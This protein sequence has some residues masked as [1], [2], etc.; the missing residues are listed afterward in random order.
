MCVPDTG[1]TQTIISE[2]MA[3][4]ANLN[5]NNANIRLLNASG[6]NMNV[7]GET[8][9][10]I[11]NDKYSID[12]IAIVAR[13]V[14]HNV[15]VSWHDLQRLGVIPAS[16][17]ACATASRMTCL[18][19]VMMGEFP[20]VFKDEL[21]SEPMKVGEMRIHLTE[22]YVPYKVS[23]P[24]QVP[25]RFQ[26]EAGR[27]V[28]DLLESG[29]ITE[30]RE[31]TDWCAPAFFVP[32]ADGKRVRLVTDY[33]RLNKFVRR[34]VHPFPSVKEIV[35]SIPTGMK[36]FAKMDAVHGYFQ[37]GLD[38]EASKLTTFILPSGR[39]RYLRAPMGLSSSSD[40][41]C[42]HSDRA[43]EGLHF[44][45]KIVDDILVWAPSLEELGNRVRQIANRC[46]ALN[47]ILSR[48]KF[49]IGEE[50][51]FAGLIINANGIKPDPTQVEALRKFPR[52]KDITGVRSFLGLANQLSGFVPDFAHMTKTLRGLTGKN[53]SFLWLQDH[54]KE[55]EEVKRLLT[56]DMVVTHF[57]PNLD[58]V[59][60]TDASR[61][62]GLGFVM[63]HIVDGRLRVVM[64]GSKS[65]TPAQ[66]RYSTVELECLGVHYAIIKCSFYLKG[67]DMFTVMTDHRPLEG[68]F[69]KDLFDLGNPRLQRIREKLGEYSFKV[70]WVPGKTHYIADAL[71]RSPVFDASDLSD[72]TIDTAR[73][74]LSETSPGGLSEILDNIDGD[75]R[76]LRED[77]MKGEIKSDRSIQFKSMFHRLSVDNELVYADGN[78]LVLP[79]K[80]VSKVL[81]G[82][83]ASHSGETKTYEMA[84]SMYYWPGMYNDVTQ[85]IQNCGICAKY[86]ASQPHGIRSTEPP[87]SYY[88]PPMQHIGLDMCEYGGKHYLV[89]VDH[90]S[91]FPLFQHMKS[92]SAKSICDQL[93]NWFNILGWP[94][95]I[96]S[97]GGPQFRGDFL[98]FCKDNGI[99]SEISAP[100]NPRSNGLAESGVKTV[101]C[102]IK[103]SIDTGVDPQRMLYSWRNVPRAH[104]YSPAQQMFG[105]QQRLDLPQPPV[106]FSQID[107]EKASQAR[108]NQ[109]NSSELHYNRD[110]QTLPPLCVNQH[111]L[112]QDPKSGAWLGEGLIQ[113]V[114][115]DGLSYVV[116]VS[117]RQCIR[118]RHMLKIWTAVKGAVKG[119]VKADHQ[120]TETPL[121]RSERLRQSSQ[122]EVLPETKWEEDHQRSSNRRPTTS[123][124][125]SSSSN[126]RLDSATSTVPCSQS[127]GT[128]LTGPQ[129][130]RRSPKPTT[131]SPS[132]QSTRQPLPRAS[133][134]APS[135]SSSPSS[136]P[137]TAGAAAGTSAS[138]GG[139]TT[140]SSSSSL[141]P[142]IPR[143]R[144]PRPSLPMQGRSLPPRLQSRVQPLLQQAP[145]FRHSFSNN[146]PCPWVGPVDHP[147]TGM[148]SP[149]LQGCTSSLP[150]RCQDS[151]TTPALP[152][153]PAG[154]A[155]SAPSMTRF[156]SMDAQQGAGVRLLPRQP[157]DPDPELSRPALD[158]QESPSKKSQNFERLKV[159]P[160]HSVNSF[161]TR[162]SAV[163]GSIFNTHVYF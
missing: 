145:R 38:E 78:R 135:F 81:K 162:T 1:S 163:P 91:G 110:K 48:K 88:G 18:K 46:K 83:H 70:K 123:W 140:T 79:K 68:V 94:S 133:G 113:A 35:Q 108:D 17:P 131:G 95:T 100:Y 20:S 9:V 107:F 12:T 90:W 22:K 130:T 80:A 157:K 16:F 64:C 8:K 105:R 150:R 36:F 19:E 92:L 143:P 121:R 127:T 120:L 138:R 58:A 151:G 11:N 34:P 82:L 147:G 125:S 15:L 146:G 87:S 51:E 13:D 57:N 63:G 153:S 40:E 29:V 44:A 101:K 62:H 109:F 65:L 129:R 98:Q 54:E 31:P 141:H 41:W 139:G 102:I 116:D 159:V 126:E 61:L 24:R 96:R 7:I 119:A 30:E 3:Q 72:M 128:Q 42:K 74:C 155:E 84:R 89:C 85:M 60:L 66:Q 50:I 93:R 132:C 56:S 73:T 142:G 154:A 76:N 112:V 103:K 33:T 23:T 47:V 104:G 156:S 69:Q 77:V 45:K 114:R 136:W 149:A 59:V 6:A 37:L 137:S 117:G 10:T 161:N 26:G 27:T 144:L 152:S 160:K 53:A 99:V 86:R 14:S 5:V 67:L 49:V 122:L 118:P 71:S 106:A 28:K 97:D 52:P 39:Y 25:L 2:R 43:I 4:H 55:F 158:Q 111:V 115:P 124:R 148:D 134:S 75:Y 21:S 32:K